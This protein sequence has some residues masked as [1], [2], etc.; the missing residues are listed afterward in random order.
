MACQ[1]HATHSYPTERQHDEADR[2]AEDDAVAQVER[3]DH[4]QAVLDDAD[5]LLREIDDAL[6]ENGS[7]SELAALYVAAFQQ[8]PG[9]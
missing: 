3:D 9:Q 1:I 5:D 4:A 2:Q 8:K 7:T 6:G